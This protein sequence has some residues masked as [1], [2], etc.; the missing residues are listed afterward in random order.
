MESDD[1]VSIVHED[2]K[3][4]LIDFWATWCP[5]C[6]APMAHNQEMLQKNKDNEVWKNVRIIG[7]SID[8]DR[9]TVKN[10]VDSKGWGAVTHYY[11][12]KSTCSDVYGVKGVPHVMLVDREGTI[13]FKG[14][15]AGRPNLE[16]D[17]TK[18]ANGEVLTGQGIEKLQ[19]EAAEDKPAELKVEEGFAEL[20]SAKIMTE[21]EEFKKVTAGLQQREDLKEA[22]KKLQ[23]AFCVI[24]YQ[25]SIHPNKKSYAK[26][27]NWRVLVGEK[28]SVQKLK[29][30]FESEVKGSFTVNNQIREM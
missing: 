10:H 23:R 22:A 9:Q 8:K 28:E 6:Q 7:L 18:L 2:G 19:Q 15:P 14:H 17:L 11:R 24:V 21:M 29:E 27:E 1:S 16:E 4:M 26:Y 30:A 13:V 5:P 25:Q 20:D 12:A 3:V